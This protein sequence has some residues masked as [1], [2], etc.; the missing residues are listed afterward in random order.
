MLRQD[1]SRIDP[2]QGTAPEPTEAPQPQEGGI[3]IQRELDRL[4]EAIVDGFPIPLTNLRLLDE[5]RL[6]ALLD[7]IRLHLPTAFQDA[8][9]IVR[10]KDEILMEAQQYAQGLVEEA[11]REAARILDEMGIV[12]QA[13]LEADQTRQQVEKDCQLA[14]EQTLA[15]IER[16]RHQAEQEVEAMRARAMEECEVMEAG[17]DEYA[18]R[19]LRNIEQQLGEMLKIIRNGRQQLE[20]DGSTPRPYAVEARDGARARTNR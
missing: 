18:D 19:V 5:E 8:R 11:E 2:T 20:R 12:R 9:D 17:A 4:E 7:A 3:D 15:E 13:K 1:S 10:R 14:Q 6:F 16:W